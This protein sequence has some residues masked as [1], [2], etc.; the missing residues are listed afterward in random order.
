[1]SV[2]SRRDVSPMTEARL[3]RLWVA[4]DGEVIDCDDLQLS[5]GMTVARHPVRFG[6]PADHFDAHLAA[7]DAGEDLEFDFDAAIA[8]AQGNGWVRIAHDSRDHLTFGAGTTKAAQNAVRVVQASGVVID[9]L[10]LEIARVEEDRIV[11]F[12]YRL[13]YVQAGMFMRFGRL[14]KGSRHEMPLVTPELVNFQAA[15]VRGAAP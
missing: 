14:P 15:E 6:L 3:P 7:I 1:M 5:H 4:P 2:G 11:S 9:E 13:D 8:L 12:F 10:D